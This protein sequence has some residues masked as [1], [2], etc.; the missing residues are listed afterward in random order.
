MLVQNPNAREI[1]RPCRHRN[2][3]VAQTKS[4]ASTVGRW[5][6]RQAVDVLARLPLDGDVRDEVRS[7]LSNQLTVGVMGFDQPDNGARLKRLN[8]ADV[9]PPASF[10]TTNVVSAIAELTSSE[11][12]AAACLDRKAAIRKADPTIMS[13]ELIE[14]RF[15]NWRRP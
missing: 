6:D 12:I 1:P 4:A 14:E 2:S 9:L 13:C 10:S 15:R 3:P 5:L 7:V 11:K 8:L